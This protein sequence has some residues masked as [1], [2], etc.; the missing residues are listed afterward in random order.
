MLSNDTFCND[1]LRANK[2]SHPHELR[3]ARLLL[4]IGRLLNR[5][6][7]QSPVLAQKADGTDGGYFTTSV[8]V[9]DACNSAAS[10]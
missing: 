9:T 4:S 2:K 8:E 5:S 10:H 6:L 7:P 1:G 3:M